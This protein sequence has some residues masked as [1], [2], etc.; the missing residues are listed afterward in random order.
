MKAQAILLTHFSQRYPKIPV[1]T[2]SHTNVGVSFDMMRVRIGDFDKLPRFE[3][4]LKVAFSE[5]SSEAA[6]EVDGIKAVTGWD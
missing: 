2:G 5:K 6:E 4:A 3:K 1:F